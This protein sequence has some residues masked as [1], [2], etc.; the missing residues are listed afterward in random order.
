MWKK[1]SSSDK[2][3]GGDIGIIVGI[4]QDTMTVDGFI[5]RVIQPGIEGYLMTGEI[6]IE[7]TCGTDN[8][9]IIIPLITVT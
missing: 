8:L 4:V 2:V 3:G 6:T 1:K 7:T 9:G 5:P